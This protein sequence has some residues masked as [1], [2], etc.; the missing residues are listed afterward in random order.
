[1]NESEVVDALQMLSQKVDGIETKLIALLG[2]D[3][4]LLVFMFCLWF[5]F[6]AAKKSDGATSS[7]WSDIQDAHWRWAQEPEELRTETFK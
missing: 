3:A 1:M 4:I 5:A 2:L 6:W 7:P